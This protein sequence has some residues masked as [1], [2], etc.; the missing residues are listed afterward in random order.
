MGNES[1]ASPIKVTKNEPMTLSALAKN[2][3]EIRRNP[4]KYVTPST[5]LQEALLDPVAIDPIEIFTGPTLLQVAKQQD[6]NLVALTDSFANYRQARTIVEP[7]RPEM[8]LNSLKRGNQIV[9]SQGWLRMRPEVWRIPV[10]LDRNELKRYL[11]AAWGAESAE[12]RAQVLHEAT[13]L[14]ATEVTDFLAPSFVLFQGTLIETAESQ[15]LAKLFVASKQP[16]VSKVR[17]TSKERAELYDLYV[18]NATY[19]RSPKAGLTADATEDFEAAINGD[20]VYL[21]TRMLPNGFPLEIDVQFVPGSAE[22]N[23]R[24]LMS[25]DESGSNPKVMYAT[26]YAKSLVDLKAG[27]TKAEYKWF[28]EPGIAGGKVIYHVS[29]LAQLEVNALVLATHPKA[30]WRPCGELPKEF[31]AQVKNWITLF[32][33]EPSH[34]K[35]PPKK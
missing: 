5:E 2:W 25:A 27:A 17:L 15:P 13:S 10:G 21:P 8:F 30:K 23:S 32:S 34:Y 24:L 31:A 4:F 11:R 35:P 28:M 14:V 26:T 22:A 7:I 33:R 1:T 20:L 18:S 29:D 12:E 3:L 6:A 9:L 19:I 16:S